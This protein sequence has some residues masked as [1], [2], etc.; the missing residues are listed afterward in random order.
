LKLFAQT[1]QSWQHFNLAHLMVATKC[2]QLRVRGNDSL[3][4]CGHKNEQVEFFRAQA[5]LVI[6]NPHAAV[7]EIYPKVANFDQVRIVIRFGFLPEEKAH[8]PN[9]GCDIL[10]RHVD[11]SFSAG[12]LA[13]ERTTLD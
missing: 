2:A 8:S 10:A 3:G 11:L 7:I 9:S 4:V 1:E 6:P 13:S 12:A 5:E